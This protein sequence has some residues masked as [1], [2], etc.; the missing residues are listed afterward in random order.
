MDG[1]WMGF[2][3]NMDA[4]H[5]NIVF[6]TLHVSM[7]DMFRGLDCLE[8][9]TCA[10]LPPETWHVLVGGRFWVSPYLWLKCA[11]WALKVA[12]F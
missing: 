11:V 9:K 12:M 7:G 5:W 8:I 6:K 4:W 3:W 10:G 1:A 2:A